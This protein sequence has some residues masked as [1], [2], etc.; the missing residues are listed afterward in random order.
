MQHLVTTLQTQVTDLQQQIQVLHQAVADAGG[1]VEDKMSQIEVTEYDIR[2]TQDIQRGK[3]ANILLTLSSLQQ[4]QNTLQHD[5]VLC[6]KQIDALEQDNALMTKTIE[7][8]ETD[9]DHLKDTT[10]QTENVQLQKDM[11]L[12]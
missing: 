2:A 5:M 10:L 11:G 12:R 3:I 8:F 9:I 1:K 7:T 4:D 6:N